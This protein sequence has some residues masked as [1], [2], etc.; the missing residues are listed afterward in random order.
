[1]HRIEDME[2]PMKYTC[3]LVLLLILGIVGFNGVHSFTV[4]GK[5]S[6]ALNHIKLDRHELSHCKGAASKDSNAKVPHQCCT[7][8]KRIGLKCFCHVMFSIEA[9]PHGVVPKAV[10]T[11]PKRCKLYKHLNTYKC[12]GSLTY[13]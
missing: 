5:S 10:A 11:I 12:G 3:F 2:G 4:C 7:L 6:H 8:V 1:M 9:K 13:Y